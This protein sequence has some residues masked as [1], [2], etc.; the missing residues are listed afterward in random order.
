MTETNY[1]E[2][3]FQAIEGHLA[4]DEYVEGNGLQDTLAAIDSKGLRTINKTF[5]SLEASSDKRSVIS[6]ALAQLQVMHERYRKIHRSTS[7]GWRKDLCMEAMN[8]DIFVCCLMALCHLYL[9]NDRQAVEA[10]ISE[11]EQAF[12]SSIYLTD[13]NDREQRLGTAQM[14]SFIGSFMGRINQE[15][16]TR[17]DT[18]QFWRNR[19]ARITDGLLEIGTFIYNGVNPFYYRYMGNMR[20]G[21]LERIGYKNFAEMKANLKARLS[22]GSEG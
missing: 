8:K 21:K 4:I 12:E 19:G 6:K 13:H 11:A 3:L 2:L 17:Q 14:D 5:E 15:D 22:L 7:Q 10:A 1:F 9:R 20:D 16:L 18:S